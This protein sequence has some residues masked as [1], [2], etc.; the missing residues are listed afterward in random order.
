MRRITLLVTT[1]IL[2]L[3]G[4]GKGADIPATPQLKT[5]VELVDFGQQVGNVT[6][7]GTS[8][9][10]SVQI[11][12]DGSEDLKLQSVTLDGDDAFTMVGPDVDTVPWGTS[13]LVTIYFTPPAAGDYSATVT[14]KSNAENAPEKTI[15][16]SGK[17]IDAP[18]S[19]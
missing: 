18:P 4:C 6:Y 10:N 14:I 19:P 8:V 12:N 9:A 7:V 17:A 15:P 13:A 16:I 1:I 11:A 2:G 3:A 5:D